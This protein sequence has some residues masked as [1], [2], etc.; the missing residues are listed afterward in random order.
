MADFPDCF[1]YDRPSL[2]AAALIEA[3]R[4]IR[5]EGALTPEDRQLQA[6]AAGYHAPERTCSGCGK[7]VYDSH[8]IAARHACFILLH[9]QEPATKWRVYACRSGGEGLHVGR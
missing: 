2:T 7:R 6:W 1:R 5:R 3:A 9:T 4:V 8:V